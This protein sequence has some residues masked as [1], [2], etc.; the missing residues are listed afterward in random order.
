VVGVEGT[1]AIVLILAPL[2][3][4]VM[5]LLIICTQNY[6]LNSALIRWRICRGVGVVA[7]VATGVLD[8]TIRCID[9]HFLIRRVS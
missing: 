7:S 3:L 2:M 9:R 8:I 6:C 1:E 4:L 5:R